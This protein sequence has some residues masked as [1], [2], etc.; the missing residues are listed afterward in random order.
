MIRA[1][2][3]VG[4]PKKWFKDGARKKAV[5]GSSIAV[6]CWNDADG[7]VHFKMFYQDPKLRLKEYLYDISTSRLVS[8]EP[9][10]E[11]CSPT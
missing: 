7:L 6:V 1:L 3:Y 9:A 10:L 11:I 4:D 8:G 5:K 2:Y